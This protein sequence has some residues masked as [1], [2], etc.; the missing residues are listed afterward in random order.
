MKLV[1]KFSGI[2][3]DAICGTDHADLWS[4]NADRAESDDAEDI[5]SPLTERRKEVLKRIWTSKGC[6]LSKCGTSKG[7][8]KLAQ[9]DEISGQKLHWVKVEPRQVKDFID[10]TKKQQ[11][12]QAKISGATQ[13]LSQAKEKG[14]AVEAAAAAAKAATTVAAAAPRSARVDGSNTASASA[15]APVPGLGESDD[16]TCTDEERKA[17]QRENAIFHQDK[18]RLMDAVFRFWADHPTANVFLFVGSAADSAKGW[19]DGR[20]PLMNNISVMHAAHT[21]VMASLRDGLEAGGR[22]ELQ[23]GASTNRSIRDGNWKKESATNLHK[24]AVWATAK[25]ELINSGVARPS[26]AAINQAVAAKWHQLTKEEKDVYI[27]EAEAS[28]ARGPRSSS[29]AAAQCGGGKRVKGSGVG[30]VNTAVTAGGSGVSIQRAA[31]S[32]QPDMGEPTLS[33][34]SNGKA[35]AGMK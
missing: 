5:W 32:S 28:T 22:N 30:V 7:L 24:Q 25:Q 33:N 14:R 23:C 26:G 10:T 34:M 17:R 4:S 29:A 18:N 16:D 1:D 12:A 8:L 35:A 3:V 15:S 6:D 27:K 21:G 31:N 2:F 13:A 19:A 20:G 9:A 11:A